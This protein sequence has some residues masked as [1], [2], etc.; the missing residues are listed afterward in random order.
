MLIDLSFMGKKFDDKFPISLYMDMLNPIP[1]RQGTF[2]FENHII[3]Y[4][5]RNNSSY[6][7]DFNKNTLNKKN[8]EFERIELFKLEV[9]NFFK[10]LNNKKNIQYANF[11]EGL[12]SLMTIKKINKR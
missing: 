5:L 4:D 10:L 6:K 3:G 1:K 12:K 11:D 7:Y 8:Y 9:F 2:F